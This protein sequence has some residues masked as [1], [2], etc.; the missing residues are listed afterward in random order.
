MNPTGSSPARAPTELVAG[1]EITLDDGRTV[2]VRRLI[3]RGGQGRVFEVDDSGG[4]HALKVVEPRVTVARSEDREQAEKSNAQTQRQLIEALIAKRPPSPAFLWPTSVVTAPAITHFGYLM[5]LGPPHYLS[6][7]ALITNNLVGDRPSIPATVGLEFC[8]ALLRLHA[9]G[10]CYRD[11]SLANVLIDQNT[12]HTLICDNDNVG[13]QNQSP[14][15]ING[16]PGFQAPEVV[17]MKASL[18]RESDLHAL[19]VFLFHLLVSNHPMHGKRWY[20]GP[21]HLVPNDVLYGSEPIFVFDPADDRNGPVESEQQRT[22]ELWQ[23]LPRFLRERFITAFTVGL[24]DPA[25]R[26]AAGVW[27]ADLARLRDLIQRCPDHIDG[28]VLIDPERE[29]RVACPRCNRPL[30]TALLLRFEHTDV[31][32]NRDTRLTGHHLHRNYDFT[33]VIG[34]VDAHP[35][36]PVWGLRNLGRSEWRGRFPDGSVTAV[37]PGAAITLVD[38]LQL[39]IEGNWASIG[40]PANRAV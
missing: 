15:L 2:R 5:P 38:G 37:A 40:H 6:A 39:M 7:K 28:E 19:A 31:V 14:Q 1:G 29:Q 22:I 4:T 34:R 33:N 13:I 10:L 25:Q 11:I 18:G 32:L 23:Q 30:R 26:V 8:D 12:G 17:Q 35:R 24:H 20:G 27:R 36:M 21:A 9:R 16:T 3:G